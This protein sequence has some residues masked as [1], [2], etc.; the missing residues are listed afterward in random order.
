MR[1]YA[2]IRL[3]PSD[4]PVGQGRLAQAVASGDASVDFGQVMLVG[5]Y[6][7]LRGPDALGEFK[8]EYLQ[9]GTW[10][11]GTRYNVQRDLLSE[12][13][14]DP[15]WGQ[16]TPYAFSPMIEKL[17]PSY[18]TP[19]LEGTLAAAV[20]SG[21]TTVDFGQAV[22]P[23]YY[24]YIAAQDAGGTFRTE[25]LRIQT[26]VS[27]TRYN[28]GRDLAE[29]NSPDPAWPVGTAYVILPAA[30][31]AAPPYVID[32]VDVTASVRFSTQLHGGFAACGFLVSGT[33]DKTYDRFN[34][35]LGAN[36]TVYDIYGRVVWDGF[37]TQTAINNAADTVEVTA[38]GYYAKASDLFFDAIYLSPEE[39]LNIIPNPSFENNV[40]DGGWNV[41]TGQGGGVSRDATQA[42]VGSASA[43]IIQPD[44]TP[45]LTFKTTIT[46]QP[47]KEYAFSFYARAQGLSLMPYV[48]VLDNVAGMAV[49]TQLSGLDG[50]WRRFE[51]QTI[52]TSP[53]TTQLTLA[54]SI[55]NRG[56]T[57]KGYLWIDGVQL[58]Q[59][60]HITPYCDGS[61]GAYH[62][63]TGT[64]HNSPSQ[65][66]RPPLYAYEVLEDCIQ[67]MPGWSHITSFVQHDQYDVGPLD[68]TGK[69]V[70][71]AIEVVMAF[72]KNVSGQPRATYFAIWEG[73][74]AYVIVEP[75][76]N[77]AFPNWLI[78]VMN[79]SNRMGVSLS[80]TDVFNKVYSVYSDAVNGTTPTLPSGDTHSQIRYGIREGFLQNGALPFT[81]THAYF[82]Q[83]AALERYRSPRQVMTL[84][85]MGVVQSSNGFLDFPYRIRAG[86]TVVIVDM[87][88]LAVHSGAIAGE[89][90][91]RVVGF[92]L[93][94]E[95][96]A[97]SNIA[98]IDI[99]S[100]DVSFDI[101]MSRLGLS[102]GLA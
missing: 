82:L 20:A 49:T 56:N 45:D 72:G 42:Y 25:H 12:N 92:V 93:R 3:N 98:R 33:H 59:K 28:V 94:T 38:S 89:A 71:E 48:Q 2:V 15:S 41:V 102:S 47:D 10:V 16:G 7:I 21:D 76:S 83:Q 32:T 1:F 24:A 100:S 67:F 77:D 8:S 58:E 52:H 6:V 62:Q 19:I 30:E 61:L 78:S 53:T 66:T 26:L 54:V 90:A 46:V 11:S 81:A 43:K 44:R 74:I 55:P 27:G 17:P 69:K 37:I 96:D 35:Y 68:F 101:L 34:L 40:T 13:A 73:R 22:T 31:M 86:Q 39:T 63:W 99:G 60:S 91:Q 87:D 14:T 64:P 88:T 29:S 79:V 4:Y 84:E 5:H 23:G 9:V 75:A 97:A 85:V 95:Y 36:V 18:L 51:F 70:R 50:T 80:L 65:R 57:P